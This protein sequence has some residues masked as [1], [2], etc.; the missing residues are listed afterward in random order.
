MYLH[1]TYEKGYQSKKQVKE[2][3]ESVYIDNSFSSSYDYS[4]L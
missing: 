2:N 3:N 4:V 1:S